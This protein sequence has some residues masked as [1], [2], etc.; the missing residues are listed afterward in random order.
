M[1]S[2]EYRILTAQRE[3]A[4]GASVLNRI[5]QANLRTSKQL[6]IVQN[7]DPEV[8]LFNGDMGII[9]IS[10]SRIHK[11]WFP[12]VK[13]LSAFRIPKHIPGYALTGH[14]SQGSEFDHVHIVLP[15]NPHSPL[16]TREWLYTAVSRARKSI[17]IWA[18]KDA[19]EKAI[20]STTKRTSGLFE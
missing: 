8:N 17:T 15:L 18:N 5:I 16:L 12:S 11:A 3:G 6:I 19:L 2:L 7:N 13:N 4:L 14:R 20:T 1:K 9:E 10:E